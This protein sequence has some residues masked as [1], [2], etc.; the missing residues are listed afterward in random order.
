MGGEVVGGSSKRSICD[1]EERLE[2]YL[3]SVYID[4]VHSPS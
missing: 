2:W 1:S 4:Q 3:H